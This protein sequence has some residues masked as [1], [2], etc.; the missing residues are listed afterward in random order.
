MQRGVGELR[1]G[2]TRSEVED[3]SELPCR[4]H[5]TARLRQLTTDHADAVSADRLEVE[6]C[7]LAYRVS[8]L[9]GRF[10]GLPDVRG[11][12]LDVHRAERDHL[13]RAEVRERL[14]V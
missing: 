12:P 14:R 13:R 8:E 5:C 3:R 10:D 6:R 4:R 2:R 1:R 9:V 11:L 7:D